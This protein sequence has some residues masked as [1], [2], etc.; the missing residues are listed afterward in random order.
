M[1]TLRRAFLVAS[2]SWAVVLPIATLVTSRHVASSAV[3][4]FGFAAYVVGSFVCHQRPERSFYLRADQM[5]VCAGGA[6]IYG[7]AA[8]AALLCPLARRLWP[9]AP[10]A[11]R[12]QPSVSRSP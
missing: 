8:L 4:L 1:R 12:L 11:R 6:G 7:G 2:I 5:P 3:Y 9:V 10:V